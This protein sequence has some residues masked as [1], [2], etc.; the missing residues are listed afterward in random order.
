VLSDRSRRKEGGSLRSWLP[1]ALLAVLVAA[2]G[3]FALRGPVE[4]ASAVSTGP[5]SPSPQGPQFFGQV[6]GQPD[7]APAA[8]ER[9][10][11]R[12]QLGENVQLTG[13]WRRIP[14]RP[15]RTARSRK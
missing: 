14:T 10:R 1:L 13:R 3:W 8:A 4:P 15:T 7:P 5:A 9:A 6:G 12:P 2:I 11:R